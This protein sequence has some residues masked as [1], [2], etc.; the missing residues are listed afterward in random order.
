VGVALVGFAF[1][2]AP[3]P[4]AAAQE[5]ARPEPRELWREFPLVEGERSNPQGTA[6]RGRAPAPAPTDRSA[7]A[8][9]SGGSLSA[10]W[11]AAIVLAAA[12]VLYLTIG[13]L[14]YAAGGRLNLSI[15]DLRGRRGRAFRNSVTVLR[16]P[17]IV[18]LQLALA[19]RA[20]RQTARAGATQMREMRR[21]ASSLGRRIFGKA[22]ALKPNLHAPPV[23]A[24]TESTANEPSTVKDNVAMYLPPLKPE[25][26]PAGEAE[27]ETLEAEAEVDSAPTSPADDELEIL[28]A[29]LARSAASAGVER[30]EDEVETLKAKLA[31]D[32]AATEGDTTG[33]VLKTKLVEGGAPAK[34]LPRETGDVA[35]LKEKLDVRDQAGTDHPPSS[36]NADSTV[37]EPQARRAANQTPVSRGRAPA[38]ARGS[39][40]A[41][42]WRGS[43]RAERSALGAAP[44]LEPVP[45]PS[46]L[47]ALPVRTEQPQ[48]RLSECRIDW[49][50]G[51]V[52]SAFHAVTQTTADEEELVAESSFFRWRKP[53]P[54]PQSG[55]VAEAH[56]ALVERLQRDGWSVVGTGEHWY[57]L[58][59]QRPT[60][61]R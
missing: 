50:R 9:G 10:A 54:P 45:A 31:G 3:L 5:P 59:L 39:T 14:S 7:E 15:D 36:I 26:T 17:G 20:P 2:A 16:P 4:Q 29:K 37:D 13:A 11:I 8:E 33:N 6:E 34:S 49:W 35:S 18:G 38:A 27:P 48:P 1:L 32:A 25:S 56:S 22:A 47:L 41:P 42:P 40:A 46:Q 21:A 44:H 58:Q 55:P 51:Y 30:A 28:K 24:D 52:K 60:G 19:N 53:E 57:E 12:L 23:P 43:N 61:E